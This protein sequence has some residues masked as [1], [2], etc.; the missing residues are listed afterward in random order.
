MAQPFISVIIN[1]YNYARFVATAVESALAQTY[2]HK[3]IIVVD[4]GSTDES[5]AVLQPYADRVQLIFKENG[6][7]ASAFHAG[8]AAARGS[9]I[10]FLDA[11]DYWSPQLLE[12]VAA[13]WDD[14]VAIM[15][16]QM[17]CVDAEGKPLGQVFPLKRPYE[18]DLRPV[19]QRRIYYSWVPTSGNAFARR[20][21]EAI[22]PL[23]VAQWR[24]SADVPLLLGAPFYGKFAFIDE[25]LAYYRVHGANLYYGIA[26]R[27]ERLQ[28]EVRKGIARER[29]IREHAQRQ[30]LQVHPRLGYSLPALNLAR[31]MLLLGRRTI[32]EMRSDT[33]LKLI[34]HGVRSVWEYDAPWSFRQRLGW[35]PPFGLALV[36]PRRALEKAA[37]IIFWGASE[38]EI[39][40]FLQE[41][42]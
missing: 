38:E 21:L 9:V 20:A 13:R 26:A 14:S 25:T 8:F 24:I 34:Y 36:H 41:V 29:I 2:P 23:D 5:R 32:P 12:R 18:G 28:H 31:L 22:F 30:G 40:Q 27:W 33:R 1:N 7:Q 39:A 42:G 11:D 16:W 37:R 3:E 17:E 4:D 19:L 15:E 10:C 35:M 6:G